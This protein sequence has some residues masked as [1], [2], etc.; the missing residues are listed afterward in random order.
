MGVGRREALGVRQLAAA[1]FLCSNNVSVT[2]P[3]HLQTPFACFAFFVVKTSRT[4]GRS[5][6]N[7]LGCMTPFRPARKSHRLTRPRHARIHSDENSGRVGCMDIASTT[8]HT[9]HAKSLL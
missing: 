9:K 2:I 4:I 6:P 8:K 7:P 5:F 1:L 3:R